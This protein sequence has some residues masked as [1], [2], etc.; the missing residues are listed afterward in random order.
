VGPALG[1]AKG[2]VSVVHEE[3]L[4]WFFQPFFDRITGQIIGLASPEFN[5]HDGLAVAQLARFFP[6]FE[7]AAIELEPSRQG[8]A[9]VENVIL[10]GRTELFVEPGPGKDPRPVAIGKKL[11]ERLGRIDGKC[12]YALT[13]EKES[14]VLNQVTGKKYLPV[15]NDTEEIQVDYGVIRRLF[16]GPTENTVVLEGVHRLGT[17]GV[18]KVLTNRNYLKDIFDLVQKLEKAEG[19]T[20][21]DAI[22]LEILVEAKFE[23]EPYGRVFSFGN[24][25]ARP[26]AIVYDREWVWEFDGPKRWVNQL[27][28]NISLSLARDEK[29]R[30]LSAPEE[31]PK[32]RMVIEADL[33]D[34]RAETKDLCRKVFLSEGGGASREGEDELLRKLA[35]EYDR[36]NMTLTSDRRTDRL[37]DGADSEIRRNRKVFMLYLSLALLLGRGFPC[38]EKFIESILPYDTRETGKTLRE[39]LV[40]TVVGRL[41]DG[42]FRRLLGAAGSDKGFVRIQLRNDR[43]ELRLERLALALRLRL[44]GA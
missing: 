5:L 39:Y 42:G 8:L 43:Y 7:F 24:I 20:L 33:R 10:V 22:P 6:L 4:E 16:V 21:D 38:D 32:P 23:S 11:R 36:F 35:G 18:A 30:R 12:C 13:S 2:V 41:R 14:V 29:P 15:L 3:F 17:L 1:L 40:G 25:S 34:I 44:D 9:P 19:V 27:P 31:L 28:W 37:P 26:L